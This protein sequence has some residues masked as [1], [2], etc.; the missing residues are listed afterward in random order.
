MR[1]KFSQSFKVQAVE[2]AL[3]RSNVTSLKEISDS[4]GVGQSTLQ[5]WIVKARNQEFE[6]VSN[7]GISSVGG[8]VKERRPQDWS[9]EEKLDMIIRC[10]VLSEDEVADNELA[11]T[12]ERRNQT[13]HAG[14]TTVP[15][16]SLL[17]ALGERDTDGDIRRLANG[18]KTLRRLR[19][20]D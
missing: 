20:R 17:P 18:R 16:R 8:R 10:A 11:R 6:T 15:K 5:K 13:A 7:E 4:L 12:S 19:G 3:S 14:R 9:S 2:K 1:A